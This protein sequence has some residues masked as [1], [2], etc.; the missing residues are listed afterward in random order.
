M[1]LSKEYLT[2]NEIGLAVQSFNKI[3]LDPVEDGELRKAALDAL[4]ATSHINSLYIIEQTLPALMTKLPEDQEVAQ[5]DSYVLTALKFICPT[6]SVYIHAAPLLLQKLDAICQQGKTQVEYAQAIASVLLNILQT[7][8][9]ESHADLAKEVHT[10]VPYVFRKVIEASLN[11]SDSLYLDPQLL[12]TL[13]LIVITILIKVDSSEQK[14]F[15]DMIFKSFVQGDLVEFMHT[16]GQFKPLDPTAPEGQQRTV[17]LFSAVICSLRKDVALPVSS[18]E[19]F[20]NTMVTLAL[21]SDIQTTSVSRMIGSLINKW[22]DNNA[23]TEYVKTTSLLLQDTMT[24]NPRALEVYLWITKALILRAHPLGYELTD[25]V[26]EWC[27]LSIQGVAHGFD[28]LVRDDVYALNKSLFAT[29]TLLYKQRFFSYSLPKLIQGYHS[30]QS[31]IK[32]NYLIALSFLLKNVPKQILLNELPPLIPLLIQSLELPDTTLRVS[33][34]NTFK[35]AVAEA[36]ET[37]S[38]QVSMILP[39]LLDTTLR[40]STLNTFKLAVAE[41]PETISSQVSMILPSLL[42][43]LQDRSSSIQVRVA[44]LNCLSEFPTSLPKD[45]LKPHVQSV[46]WKLKVVLDDRKRIVRKEAV[47]CRSKWFVIL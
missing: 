5:Q 30:T 47:D 14:A 17:Q 29:V 19:D 42:G 44:V 8:A 20:L 22:K 9:T 21:S 6:E 27:G 35:L 26:I 15:M 40:V 18:M 2:P 36:P 41:A 34:L 43:I 16:Q 25:K 37:I 1:V 39:S 28:I 12:Q 24:Q 46:L 45:V 3:L 7:K 33:T 13:S 32:P 11:T 23:L 31:D 38:S 4:C 10:M